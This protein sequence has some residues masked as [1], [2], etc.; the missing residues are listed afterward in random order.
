M[1][2][3][4]RGIAYDVAELDSGAFEISR[5]G[6]WIGTISPGVNDSKSWIEAAILHLEHGKPLPG[7]PV[8]HVSRKPKL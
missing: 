5:E 4:V 3:E 1:R 6:D 7:I 2:L 8:Y